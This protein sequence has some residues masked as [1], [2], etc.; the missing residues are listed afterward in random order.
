MPKHMAKHHFHYRN[1]C[2]GEMKASERS[3]MNN[4]RILSNLGMLRKHVLPKA[5]V[6]LSVSVLSMEINNSAGP[7]KQVKRRPR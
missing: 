6:S 7:R 1:K 4:I 5:V 3:H 2:F